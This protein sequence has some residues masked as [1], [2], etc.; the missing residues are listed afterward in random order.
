M[1]NAVI[2]MSVLAAIGRVGEWSHV[3]SRVLAKE[4]AGE[5]AVLDHTVDL[6]TTEAIIAFLVTLFIFSLVLLASASM[7]RA[8]E[9]LEKVPERVKAMYANGL[10][11]IPAWQW[12]GVISAFMGI[13][14]GASTDDDIDSRLLVAAVVISIAFITSVVQVLLEN[15]VANHDQTSLA[16]QVFN[17][18]RTSLGLG[19]GF[20]VNVLVLA[21]LHGSI[22]RLSIMSAYVLCLTVLVSILQYNLFPLIESKKGKY[23]PLVLRT[24]SF[25]LLACNFVVGWAWKGLIDMFMADYGPHSGLHPVLLQLL[26]STL[27]TLV[28]VCLVVGITLLSEGLTSNL[29]GIQDLCI[30]ASAMNVGWTWSIFALV[31]LKWFEG[32]HNEGEAIEVGWVW[33]FT[34]AVVFIA[35]L[36][37]TFLEVLIEMIEPKDPEEVPLLSALSPRKSPRH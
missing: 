4:I 9:R 14:L 34:F 27:I 5:D 37:A 31:C 22:H 7:S 11:F 18:L 30:L 12:K 15:W 19:L 28:L 17:T 8:I 32:E 26:A 25:L 21:I 1:L 23:H 10:G 13:C 29:P 6:T 35:T 3:S 20:A 2:T 33:V 24:L 36:M 16:Y